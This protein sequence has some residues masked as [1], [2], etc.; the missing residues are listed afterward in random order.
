MKQNALLDFK[1]P[2][3]RILLGVAFAQ[4][5]LQLK[6]AVYLKEP[7]INQRKQIKIVLG[8]RQIRVQR[9]C[10]IIGQGD[11]S[12][13]PPRDGELLFF[14]LPGL[15][16]HRLFLRRRRVD[17]VDLASGAQQGKNRQAQPGGQAAAHRPHLSRAIRPAWTPRLSPC[18]RWDHQRA[19][20]PQQVHS[21][22]TAICSR[23]TPTESS[24]QRLRPLVS[25]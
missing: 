24:R 7:L 16:Y 25:Q 15:V 4:Q 17:G 12:L 11:G 18:R 9:V 22:L 5:A 3:Q 8:F 20:S 1:G 13:L 2:L 6:I 23:G 19:G 14:L 10:R 21:S